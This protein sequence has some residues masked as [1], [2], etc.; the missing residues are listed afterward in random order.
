MKQEIS[1]EELADAYERKTSVLPRI[2]TRKL[3]FYHNRDRF[4]HPEKHMQAMNNGT[5]PVKM[6]SPQSSQDSDYGELCARGSV[7]GIAVNSRNGTLSNNKVH[8]TDDGFV[9]SP[10]R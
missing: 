6:S 10:T 3:S 8:E 5:S 4:E 9:Y 7:L 2:D 1:I